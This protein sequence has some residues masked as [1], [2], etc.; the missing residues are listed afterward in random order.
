[1]L[2]A[3]QGTGRATCLRGN[4]N[5]IQLLWQG[6]TTLDF[7]SQRKQIG[8]LSQKKEKQM[9]SNIRSWMDLIFNIYTLIGWIII[10]VIGVILGYKKMITV[11]RDY[12]DMGLVFLLGLIPIVLMYLFQL[13]AKDNQEVGFIFIVIVESILFLWIVIRTIQDNQ[14]PIG[15]LFALVTKLS[16]AIL[17]II[18][19]LDFV[20]PAGKTSAKRASSRRKGFA[21]L[22]LL[23]PIVFALVKNREGIF[24][25]ER[26][27]AG[28]GIRV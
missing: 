5:H 24:N 23:T 18:N 7:Y 21:F 12:N 26:T 10:V 27:L 8:H 3:Y 17:F 20:T 4:K 6:R 9:E 14:N 11:F 22:L 15:I 28:R 2:K 19:L 16:L 25:P 13:V 1:M